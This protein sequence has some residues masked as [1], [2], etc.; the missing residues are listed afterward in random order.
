MLK[1][2]VAAL[3][4]AMFSGIASADRRDGRHEGRHDKGPTVRDHRDNR[5]QRVNRPA[6][7]ADRHAI[8]RRPVYVNNG[9]FVF[10]SGGSRAY[11]RPV[12]RARYYNPRVRPVMVVENYGSEPGYIW[13]RGQWMW[14]GNEWQWNDGHF[15]PDPQYSNYYDDGS[16]DYSFN[17]SVG[18]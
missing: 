3:T 12:I 8:S 9:R 5:P 6:Q 4:L 1:F 2:T 7:R 14:S 11:T 15:V 18:G 17:I 16:Y 10:A 13:V